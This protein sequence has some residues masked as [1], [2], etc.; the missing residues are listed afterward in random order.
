MMMKIR[1]CTIDAAIPVPIAVTSCTILVLR[2]LWAWPSPTVALTVDMLAIVEMITLSHAEK[3][4]LS[5]I[6][7]VY[8]NLVFVVLDVSMSL[9]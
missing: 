4:I 2:E 3:Y 5:L 1:I 7:G 9:S 6:D 8:F